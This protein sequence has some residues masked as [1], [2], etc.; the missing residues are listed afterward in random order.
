MDIRLF[1]PTNSHIYTPF[2]SATPPPPLLFTQDY[3]VW[4]EAAL[5]YQNPPWLRADGTLEP[6]LDLSSSKSGPRSSSSSV[7]SST[8]N[9]FDNGGDANDPAAITAVAGAVVSKLKF[10]R[11]GFWWIGCTLH[12]ADGEK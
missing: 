6:E 11:H 3:A 8:N 4:D 12:D 5:C 9:S 7:G 2:L 1:F 10:S